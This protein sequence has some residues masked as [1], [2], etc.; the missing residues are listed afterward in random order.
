MPRVLARATAVED[1]RTPYAA[2]RGHCCEDVDACVR[3][4]AGLETTRER[5]VNTLRRVPCRGPGPG[6]PEGRGRAPSD[7]HER[8]GHDPK[9]PGR[10]RGQHGP[11]V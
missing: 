6:F 3:G 2:D 9:S 10:T 7:R 1:G 8:Q 5:Q 4:H 11:H